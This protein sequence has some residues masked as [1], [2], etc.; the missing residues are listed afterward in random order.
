[1][2]NRNYVLSVWAGFLVTVLVLIACAVIVSGCGAADAS[3][4]GDTGQLSQDLSVKIQ[5]HYI[6]GLNRLS[7]NALCQ[8]VPGG[9]LEDCYVPKKSN[10]TFCY[11]NGTA[12]EKQ[13]FSIALGKV[14]LASNNKFAWTQLPDGCNVAAVDWMV[15]FSFACGASGGGS[16][17]TVD[18]VCASETQA[19]AGSF[20]GQANGGLTKFYAFR[21][22][23]PG[24][25]FIGAGVAHVDS[26]DINA[27][28]TSL[29]AT[30]KTQFQD[31]L[32]ANL[33]MQM[34]GRGIRSDVASNG[35][36]TGRFVTPFVTRTTGTAGDLCALQSYSFANPGTFGTSGSCAT[37]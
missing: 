6:H 36:A 5:P 28:L 13:Q 25:S 34:V 33:A 19:P 26:S 23:V 35:A 29:T 14:A 31:H 2:F 1:M 9:G 32:Y 37:D 7:Q 12:T 10:Q 16:N 15:N 18:F 17:G 20:I 11:F 3:D 22:P 30:Q 27:R 4:A 21:D 8:G 24:G